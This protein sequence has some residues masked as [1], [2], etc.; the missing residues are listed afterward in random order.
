MHSGCSIQFKEFYFACLAI[1]KVVKYVCNF[2]AELIIF[3][4]KVVPSS[5]ILHWYQ[6]TPLE[7]LKAS[8]LSS[9]SGKRYLSQIPNFVLVF[10]L[11]KNVQSLQKLL[12]Y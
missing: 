1:K 8:R 6:I 9:M 4:K 11:Y 3:S 7:S 2:R 5:L 10:Y 12:C